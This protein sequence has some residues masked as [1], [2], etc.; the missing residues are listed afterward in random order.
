MSRSL[1]GTGLQGFDASD[2]TRKPTEKFAVAACVLHIIASFQCGGFLLD[3][4]GC[5]LCVNPIAAN[6]IV[7]KD[8]IVRDNRL[9]AADRESDAR[10][11]RAVALILKETDSANLRAASLEVLRADRL[12]LLIRM[13][14]LEESVRPAVDGASVLLIA[15]DPE[16]RQTPPVDLLARIFALT[17]AEAEVAI[18]IGAGRR[19]AKIAS[20]RGAKI[21]TVRAQSK[22]VFAK[23]RRRSQVELAALLTRLATLA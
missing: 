1:A 13:L 14:H 4:R 9:V 23:T 21:E 5:I 17:P 10:L 22:M 18:G 6:T 19:I 16:I 2:A 12:P 20:D 8:L 15:F 3:S 11:Q 7:G